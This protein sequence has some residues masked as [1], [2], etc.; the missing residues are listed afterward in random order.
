MF[1]REIVS[2]ERAVD[3]CYIKNRGDG[4]RI[5]RFKPLNFCFRFRLPSPSSRTKFLLFFFFIKSM[6][7]PLPQSRFRSR[8]AGI[9]TE[10]H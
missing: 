9:A 1:N 5:M 10:I 7:S 4:L 3:D 8:Q 2:S 6:V